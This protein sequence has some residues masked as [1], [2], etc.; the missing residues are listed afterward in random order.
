VLERRRLVAAGLAALRERDAARY[1]LL[2]EQLRRYERRRARFG[3]AEGGYLQDVAAGVASRFVVREGILAL[4]LGPLACAGGAAFVL[5]YAAVTMA[6]RLIRTSLDQVAT[7][8]ILAGVIFYSLWIGT[9]AWLAWRWGGLGAALLTA[10]GLPALGVAALVAIEREAAVFEIV[11]SYLA[12][13]WTRDV[14]ERRLVRHRAS[15]AD[16]LDETYRWLE[17]A[18]RRT[19]RKAGGPHQ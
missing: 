1:A 11:R 12:S 4:L 6:A 17:G 8:K 13:R 2:Y 18:S 3:L 10:I 16:L 19:D 7:V 9:L 5:P 15:V 14:T